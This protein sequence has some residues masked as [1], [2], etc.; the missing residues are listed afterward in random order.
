MFGICMTDDTGESGLGPSWKWIVTII[1]AITVPLIGAIL[2]WIASNLQ[3]IVTEMP[4]VN[5]RIEVTAK[6]LDDIHTELASIHATL[7]GEAGARQQLEYET[8]SLADR[9][10]A[11]ENND[12]TDHDWIVA[13]VRANRAIR[14][15]EQAK[16]QRLR[17]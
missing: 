9:V 16:K 17:Q 6:Q 5:Y 3:S 8:K 10:T 13:Q 11:V 2:L 15:A 7:D 12:G 14:E 4:M 1:S